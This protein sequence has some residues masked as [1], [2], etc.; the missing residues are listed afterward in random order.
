MALIKEAKVKFSNVV[1]P[2]Y[3]DGTEFQECNDCSRI[4]NAQ[5]SITLV[6]PKEQVGQVKKDAQKTIDDGK[7]KLTGTRKKLAN[8]EPQTLGYSEQLDENG[9]P[10]GNY[11]LTA[12]LKAVNPKNGK[13]Q[14]PKILDNNKQELELYSEFWG[15][16]VSMKYS[17][18]FYISGT[19]IG[20]TNYIV[21]IRVHELISGESV[22][23]LFDDEDVID[24][25][26][27]I[28]AED[29]ID[30]YDIPF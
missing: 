3:H 14:F 27:V 17:P 15:S 19:N 4:D 13:R 18:Y 23:D 9:E 6:V 16:I 28:D 26:D 1:V 22:D 30:D 7:E 20:V 11:L 8:K 29:V 21:G 24:D 10:T 5:Y 25:D 12:K 2:V